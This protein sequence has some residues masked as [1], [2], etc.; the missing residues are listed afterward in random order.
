MADGKMLAFLLVLQTF[1]YMQMYALYIPCPQEAYTL[2][3]LSHVHT[4]TYWG[5]LH[6]QHYFGV[7]QQA[8]VPGGNP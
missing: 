4:Y 2:Q 1:I 6:Y 8:R 7:S 3:F 5:Q